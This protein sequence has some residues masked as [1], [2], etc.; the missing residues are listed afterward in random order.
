MTKIFSFIKVL[1]AGNS[2]DI[3]IGMLNFSFQDI[4]KYIQEIKGECSFS[5]NLQILSFALIF[6][7]IIIEKIY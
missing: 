1:N 6:S 3:L 7:V 5:E 4:Y 2:D